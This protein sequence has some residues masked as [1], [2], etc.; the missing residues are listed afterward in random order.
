MSVRGDRRDSRAQSERTDH[1]ENCHHDDRK[2][3]P[4]LRDRPGR[5]MSGLMMSERTGIA[6]AASARLGGAGSPAVSVRLVGR[7]TGV[8]GAR[9]LWMRI[10]RSRWKACS[11]RVNRKRHANS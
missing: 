5:G 9:Y 4:E 2:R 1:Q 3:V 10:A 11:Q 8:S 6:T 7:E